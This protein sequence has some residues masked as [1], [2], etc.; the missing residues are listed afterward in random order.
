MYIKLHEQ[1]RDRVIALCDRE[2]LGGIF[3]QGQLCLDLKKHRSFYEGELCTEEEAMPKLEGFASINAVG[4]KS[5]SVLKK[6]GLLK[7]SGILIQGVPHA[8][9]Y[10]VRL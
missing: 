7:G 8:Q 9:V 6:A 1:G 2:L 3:K 4:K 10:R 5:I